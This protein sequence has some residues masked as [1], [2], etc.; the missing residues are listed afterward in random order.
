[1]GDTLE[2]ISRLWKFGAALCGA[3][4][5]LCSDVLLPAAHPWPTSEP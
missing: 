1:M 3:G 5:G 2:R 4:K